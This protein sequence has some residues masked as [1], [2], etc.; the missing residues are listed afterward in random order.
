MLLVFP[1]PGDDV[2]RGHRAQ[3]AVL[4]AQERARRLAPQPVRP[5]HDRR[6]VHRRVPVEHG[7]DL[8]AADVLPGADDH[9]VA[10]VAD[11]Q[12]PV[13]VHHADVARV[14]PP[15]VVVAPYRGVGR[16]VVVEVAEHDGPAAEHDL[17]HRGAVAGNAA[18]G[19]AVDDVGLGHAHR[20]HA[21]PRLE[22]RALRVGE[23]VPLG[24]PRARHRQPRSLR[25][26]VPVGDLKAELLRA[27][28]DRHRRRRAGREDAHLSRRERPARALG[29]VG[30]HVEH[31]GRA[32]EVGHPV[33]GDGGVHR[34]GSD[35]SCTRWC[36]RPR[37][38]PT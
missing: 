24:L 14:E 2:A 20:A 11:L 8:E 6:L 25:Q 29:R 5:S 37:P 1:A 33:A 10:P 16:R 34:G 9:V 19:L 26:P 27:L 22:P 18:A 3:R 21:L 15:V 7:L 31:D 38:S 28:Q 23:P 12:V 35:G 17:A 32:A 4:D 30:Q 13:R 36:R